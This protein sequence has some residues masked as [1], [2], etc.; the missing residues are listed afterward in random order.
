MH[1]ILLHSLIL[2][3]DYLYFIQQN[4]SINFLQSNGWSETSKKMKGNKYMEENPIISEIEE[5]KM[6]YQMVNP[7]TILRK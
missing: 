1:K 4:D 5:H 3:L 6:I 2:W 7:A